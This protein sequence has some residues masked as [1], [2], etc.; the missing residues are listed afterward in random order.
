MKIKYQILKEKACLVQ[1]YFGEWSTEHYKKYVQILVKDPEWKYVTKVF[2]DFREANLKLVNKDLNYIIQLENEIL[3][4]NCIYVLLVDNP[5]STASIHL[6]K[7]ELEK[8]KLY[9][10]YCS[11]VEFALKL[12]CIN[13]NTKEMEEILKTLRN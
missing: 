8:K 10:N 4:K 7:K 9:C 11:T 13:N 5:I 12:L 2:S 6:Y 1:K 3:R